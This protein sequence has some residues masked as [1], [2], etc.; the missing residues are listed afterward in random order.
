MARGICFDSSN[1][2][3]L[4][5]SMRNSTELHPLELV[6]GSARARARARLARP[7][8]S[9]SRPRAG[10]GNNTQ[11]KRTTRSGD[12]VCDGEYLQYLSPMYVP[13][14]YH[15][16]APLTPVLANGSSRYL[17]PCPHHARCT[18]KHYLPSNPTLCQQ[19]SLLHVDF[20]LAT[21]L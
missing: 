21:F 9:P 13:P 4:T 1:I 18:S 10:T 5:I 2:E 7:A 3:Y 16:Q 12:Q 14:C 8:P 6:P 17:T 11:R 19:Q 15:L 20:A